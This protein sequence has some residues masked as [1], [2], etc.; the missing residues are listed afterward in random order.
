MSVD[1]KLT[2]PIGSLFGNGP[3]GSQG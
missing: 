2:P 1:S 3:G